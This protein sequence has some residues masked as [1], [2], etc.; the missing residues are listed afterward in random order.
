MLEGQGGDETVAPDV[1]GAAFAFVQLERTGL[2]VP[3]RRA[4]T[5]R[6][7]HQKPRP[8]TPGARLVPQSCHAR[9]HANPVLTSSHPCVCP[10]VS[11]RAGWDGPGRTVP[12]AQT[13]VTLLLRRYKELAGVKGV[14]AEGDG[15]QRRELTGTAAGSAL[16]P[17]K[18]QRLAAGQPGC[19][20]RVR[21]MVQH[22]CRRGT[23]PCCGRVAGLAKLAVRKCVVAVAPPHGRCT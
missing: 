8:A 20:I 5:R 12:A 4:A 21:N 1:D 17:S 6:A 14:V 15:S 19:R 23:R 22:G 16:H 9:S 7:R 13:A 2:P 10:F 3:P 11:T 18:P